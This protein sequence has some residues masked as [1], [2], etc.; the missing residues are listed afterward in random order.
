[1]T[2]RIKKSFSDLDVNP[3]LY[4]LTLTYLITRTIEKFTG[5]SEFWSSFW[6]G[7]IDFFGEDDFNFKFLYTMIYLNIIYFGFGFL[8]VIMDITNKPKFMQKYKTQPEQHQPLD[9]NKFLPALMVVIFNQFI[10]S[11]IAIYWTYRSGDWMLSTNIRETPTFTRLIAEIFGFGL[12]YEFVFY[13]SHRLLHHKSIY[14]YIHKVH[15][16]WQAPVALMAAYCHPIE[17]IVSNLLPFIISNLLFRHTLATT[18]VIYAVAIISTLGD[19]SGYHLP[20]LHSPQFHD[21][22]HLKFFEN[23]GSNGFIDKFHGTNKKFEESIQGLRHRTLWSLKSSNELF[24][25]D[26][27]TEKEN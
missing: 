17:H 6:N 16:K 18:W 25:D 21:Y 20:F 13:Y 1:M 19:H 5:T 8:Y 3:L 10:L 7:I 23:F 12:T 9:M 2:A 11:G 4:W 27:V 14:Q 26:K 24:P 22:H 15:H